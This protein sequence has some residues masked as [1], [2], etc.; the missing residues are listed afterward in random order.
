MH[1]PVLLLVV[2][3]TC[4]A[5]SVIAFVPLGYG[6]YRIIDDGED[7]WPQLTSYAVGQLTVMALMVCSL[8]LLGHS[9]SALWVWRGFSFISAAMAVL[10]CVGALR[11]KPRSYDQGLVLLF[12]ITGLS[13]FFFICSVITRALPYAGALPS[14]PYSVDSAPIVLTQLS[15]WHAAL[16]VILALASM[17]CGLLFVAAA[18]SEGPL[19]FERTGGGLGGSGGGWE[20]SNSMTYLLG[21][22]ASSALLLGLI[23]HNDSMEQ[24]RERRHDAAAEKAA[25]PA[26]VTPP[27][28]TAHKSETATR[29]TPAAS[30]AS[31]GKAEPDAH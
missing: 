10:L 18:R 3:W 20:V 1:V 16:C 30:A 28:P 17:I 31:G 2:L 24:E 8:V 12:G 21:A 26:E 5:L 14:E 22:V 25:T 4:F 15:F 23:F 19:S 9:S 29:T 13:L 27:T 11:Q 6:V 7:E